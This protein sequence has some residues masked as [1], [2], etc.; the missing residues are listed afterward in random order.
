MIPAHIALPILL[1]ILL[2][3]QS[4]QPFAPQA[5][6]MTTDEIRAAR[7]KF[8]REMKEDTKRPWDGIDLTGPHAFEKR[9]ASKKK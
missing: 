6:I 3:E 5:P 1:A 8:D 4:G 7:K 2:V 9:P